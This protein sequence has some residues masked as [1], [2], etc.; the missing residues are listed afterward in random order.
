MR[1]T[2]RHPNEV[3]ESGEYPCRCKWERHRDGHYHHYIV[4]ACEFDNKPHA[5]VKGYEYFLVVQ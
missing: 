4:P 2:D 5:R 1:E 3:A